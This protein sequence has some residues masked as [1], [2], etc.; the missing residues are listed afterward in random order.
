MTC[1]NHPNVENMQHVMENRLL[2]QASNLDLDLLPHDSHQH[3]IELHVTLCHFHCARS[4][5]GIL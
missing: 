5:I 1:N 3:Q 2:D 4:C